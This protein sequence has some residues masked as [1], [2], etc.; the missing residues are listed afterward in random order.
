MP[1][2]N[3]TLLFFER[4]ITDLGCMLNVVAAR[5]VHRFGHMYQLPNTKPM[6]NG[7][8]HPKTPNHM[9]KGGTM[10]TMVDEILDKIE[11]GNIN[12][13]DVDIYRALFPVGLPRYLCF[14]DEP[15]SVLTTG[16]IG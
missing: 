5:M 8:R 15:D 10:S 9:F 4:S 6:T 14:A 7:Q 2:K 16:R 13:D 12:T 11:T 1:T 3:G